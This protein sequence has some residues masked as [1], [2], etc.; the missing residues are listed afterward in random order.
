MYQ[1]VPLIPTEPQRIAS[2]GGS[3]S[4][5]PVV[6]QLVQI[7]ENQNDGGVT[8]A[9][10]LL[11]RICNQ[12]V[13]E[14]KH[15]DD[16]AECHAARVELELWQEAWDDGLDIIRQSVVVPP[17]VSFQA[18]TCTWFGQIV[19][20]VGFVVGFGRIVGDRPDDQGCQQSCH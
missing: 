11:D 3:A 10:D 1:V 9:R 8:K 4:Q 19:E 6:L 7:Y 13:Y 17:Q 15:V 18:G 20:T 12:W 5:L 2:V 14:F 16:L